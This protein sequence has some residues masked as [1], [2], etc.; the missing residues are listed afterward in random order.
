MRLPPLVL[1]LLLLS[2]AA[3]A[4]L[5]SF[6]VGTGRDGSLTVNTRRTIN[7]AMRMPLGAQRGTRTLSVE[8]VTAP[9]VGSLLLIHQTQGFASSTPSGGTGPTSPGGVGSWEMARVSSVTAGSPMVI[10]LSAP[11]VNTYDAPGSQA[12]TVPEYTTVNVSGSGSLVA[13]AWNGSS[14]GIL[15]FLANGAVT[16][17]SSINADGMG[18]RGGV[19]GENTTR[20]N[21]TGDDLPTSQG[22]AFKGEGLVVERYGSASG[23][24]N[25]V[26]AG[27]GG[28]CKDAGGGGGGHRGAGGLGGRTAP[29][30]GM[31]DMGGQGGV[32][33]D[34]TVVYS[35]L[36][37]GGGGA[38]EGDTGDGSSGGA[39]GGA[40]L[41]RALSV[42]GGGTFSANG[43]AAAAS[44]GEDGAGG[45]GAGGSVIVRV[46]GALGCSQALVQG[47]AGG[48]APSASF[49]T[50]PGGG[51]AGGVLL[52]HGASVL[53]SGSHAGGAAGTAGSSG[54]SYGATAGGIGEMKQFIFPYQAP[55]TPVITEPIVNTTVSTRPTI[56]GVADPGMRVIISVDGVRVAEVG[57]GVDGAFV[58]VLDP[59]ASELAVGTH[60][61]TAVSESMG[62][63]SRPASQVSFNARSQAADAGLE[64]PIIVV[65]AEG[66]VTGPTPYIAGV[67]V[68]ARTV[69][70]YIDNREEAIVT[71]D[72]QGRFRY[73]IPADSPLAVGPHKVNAHGHD[74]D[75]NSSGSSP[76]TRF[77]VVLPDPDAGS[78]T[79]DAGG[80][81]AGSSGP[82]AGSG[83][84]GSGVTREVPVLVVP[85]EGEWVDPTPLFAGVAQPGATVSLDVDGTRVATVVADATGAFRHTLAAESALTS[86]AHAVS[87]SMLNSESGTP[88]PKSPDTG[89]QVRG[90]TALDVGCGGCGA[91]PTGAAAAWV[92]LIGVAALLRQRRRQ[93]SGV[94]VTP[95]RPKCGPPAR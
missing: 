16:N 10:Q 18:F 63:Y 45:G 91:S 29:T 21:C 31:R 69:G 51:G 13:P 39:G 9:A 42:S 95:P 85:A 26:N 46:T 25:L 30:D 56:R 50:G 28:I 53:C 87:A 52:L 57:A 88:G 2:S 4:E 73:D 65:P 66:E 14:G 32:V 44:G 89:F 15:A 84:A 54:G 92:L 8:A 11:L 76:D 72:S 33:M 19:F 60:V 70:L 94:R 93:V 27:G 79:P 37:G 74:V 40:V 62:A 71:A 17:N 75:D 78:P 86:G 12:V 64:I 58:T 7:T 6:G 36:L 55:T 3:Q 23:R 90:P 20:T 24:G 41:V 83:D 35:F 34:Y 59:P 22:G 5:D 48:N 38:G 47:G 68:N 1:V 49:Q 77:E 82:D 81:D 80:S 67:A 61:V 43:A